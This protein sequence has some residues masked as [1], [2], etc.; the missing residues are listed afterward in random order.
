MSAYQSKANKLREFGEGIEKMFL[1]GENS[2]TLARLACRHLTSNNPQISARMLE[3]VVSWIY[4]K[5]TE[6]IAL[7]GTVTHE[8]FDYSQLSPE[9]LLAVEGLIQSARVGLDQGRTL[10][11]Q[12]ALLGTNL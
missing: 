7:E 5:P 3:L 12:P 11:A 1:Q 6:T 9:Q 2:T 10:Q 8:H 4:G